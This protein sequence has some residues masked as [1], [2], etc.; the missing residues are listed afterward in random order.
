V[1]EAPK[2]RNKRGHLLALLCLSILTGCVTAAEKK[3]A[4]PAAEAEVRKRGWT[5]FEVSSVNRI[6]GGWRVGLRELPPTF[7]GHA[8]VE[9]SQDGKVTQYYPG[10]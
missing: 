9:V 4:V 7:G 10:K 5:T 6:R 1:N 3:I 2:R 8:E